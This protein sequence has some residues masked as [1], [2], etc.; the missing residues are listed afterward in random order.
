MNKGKLAAIRLREETGMDDPDDIALEDVI[1][2]RGGILQYKSMGTVG[3]CL[4]C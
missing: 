2:G 3:L 4:L 1:I